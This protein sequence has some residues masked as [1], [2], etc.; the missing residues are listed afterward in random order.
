MFQS[1]RVFVAILLQALLFSSFS[2]A[3]FEKAMEIYSA[4]RFDEAKS[5]FEAL[6]AIGDRSSL[7]NLGVM[8]YRGEYFEKN[9]VKAYILMKI[10][11]DGADEESFTRISKSIFRKFDDQQKKESEE[12]FIE[13]NS[14][15]N[16]S[17]IKANIFPRP[18]N[19]EDC[20]PEI[21]P[22]KRDAPRY[23]KYELSTGRMGLTHMEF[24]I[25]PE[26]YPRDI[27]STKSTNNAFT[28]SSVKANK[29][30]LYE[31][32]LDGKPVYGYRTVIIYKLMNSKVF[33]KTLTKELDDLKNS[34]GEGD[35]IA[36]YRYA[37]RLN[38]FRYF[39]DYLKKV[40]LQYKTA[41]EWFAKSAKNG[42][43]HA[44]Y[45]IG[46]NM[47]NGRGCEADIVNGYKWINAAAI[48]GYSPAQNALAQ[49]ALTKSDIS[50][51]KSLAAIG[52][53]RNSAQSNNFSARLL[54]AW[55]LS[56]SNVSELRNAEEALELID[57]DTR[58]YF[59]DVRIME[60]KA[61]AYAEL[62]DFKKAKK[63]QKKAEKIARKLKWEIPLI[64]ERLG[65][66]ERGKPYRGT[67]Y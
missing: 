45:E 14:I 41:N 24:T 49:S 4:G 44:Q 7:F 2:Y 32:P 60:T 36:Q 12:L 28:K 33:T 5:A 19:D 17:T 54:L 15:Y 31:P 52:W 22:I 38:T 56:T 62:G 59:D 39:K 63:Y 35:V 55:E 25:S 61:A 20:P 10:A 64:S 30:F 34:A 18:L 8:H 9:P 27:I 11:N 43:P 37:S 57:S 26:G 3:S 66:Y 48:G 42:L 23:P 1:R 13:L 21:T 65:L 50:S 58:N 51:E 29:K 46:R 16:I 47:L 6:A 67:Y 40:D 53:L